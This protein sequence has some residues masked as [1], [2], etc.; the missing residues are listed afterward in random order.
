MTAGPVRVA[1]LGTPSQPETDWSSERLRDLGR[2]G[3]TDVQVNIAWSYRPADEVLTL[4]DLVAVEGAPESGGR[5]GDDGRARRLAVVRKRTE[6][7]HDAGLRTL[8]HLGLPYQGRAGFDGAALP[9][10]VSDPATAERYD[11]A[12]GDLAG[13]LPDLDDLLIYTYDQD[14]WLCSE[15]GDCPRCSGVPL[16]RRL[17]AFLASLAARWRRLRPHGRLWWEPWE[18]SAGQALACIH[19]LADVPIGLMVHSNVGEVISTGA[20]DRF[21]RAAVA[22]AARAG[23]PIVVEVF[24]SSSNEEVEPWRHLPVP[25]VTLRQLRAVESLDG[26]A[27][28]KEYFGLQADPFDVNALAAAAHFADPGAPDDRILELLAARFERPWLAGFWRV[29]SEAYELY[30]WDASWFVRQLG[31]SEPVHA[32]SAATV[33]G[34][35]TAASEWDTP[36]WRSTR[37][38]VFQRVDDSEPHPWLLEDVQLRFQAA[39]DRMTEAFA[40]VPR[41]AVDVDAT[42]P[43]DLLAGHIRAQVSE[44]EG[45]ITRTTAYACHLRATALA[46]LLRSAPPERIASLTDELRAVLRHDADN[47]VR[48]LRRRAARPDDVAPP[49]ALQIAERWVVPGRDDL[50]AIVAAIALL[51]DD[52]VAFLD[53]YL[54]PQPGTA[55]AGQFSVTSR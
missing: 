38:A 40:L 14:A 30:P 1:V 22:G 20:A 45:F 12:L 13:R 6:A 16:H 31:R 28:I 4:E 46:A 49:S 36:A 8:L 35:Q 41:S 51:D 18:L 27:G 34:T 26:V 44:V 11:V 42:D 7:A 29:A 33:R 3:F 53:R 54:L 32:L 52:P 43:D 9:Q 24:L 19:A 23:L 10:C 50:S 2:D 37:H 55:D 25:G 15:F 21:V 5:D 17:P 48:E 47:Q 39:A